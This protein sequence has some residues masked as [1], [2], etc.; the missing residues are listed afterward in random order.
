MKFTTIWTKFGHELSI[1]DLSEYLFLEDVPPYFLNINYA[2]GLIKAGQSMK[3]YLAGDI[4][5]SELKK[6]LMSNIKGSEYLVNVNS[7]DDDY[8]DYLL[9]ECKDYPT[10]LKVKKEIKKAIKIYDNLKSKYEDEDEL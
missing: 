2:P 7:N 5:I 6:G 10:A 9:I 3:I 4:E 1:P 8:D